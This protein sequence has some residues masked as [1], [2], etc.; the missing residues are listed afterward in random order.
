MNYRPSSGGQSSK[1]DDTD[2]S[3]WGVRRRSVDAVLVDFLA[4]GGWHILKAGATGGIRGKPVRGITSPDLILA[5]V[6]STGLSAKAIRAVLAVGK[7]SVKA[8]LR[9]PELAEKIA[10][11]LSRPCPL[12]VSAFARWIGCN[13]S[14]LYALRIRGEKEIERKSPRGTDGLPGCFTQTAGRALKC[15]RG[16]RSYS[17]QPQMWEGRACGHDRTCNEPLQRLPEPNSNVIP[18]RGETRMFLTDDQLALDA[19][20]LAT[21]TERLDEERREIASIA[22]RL[23]ARFPADRVLAEAIEQFIQTTLNGPAISRAA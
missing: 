1:S 16:H 17:P 3:S 22:A 13:P 21:L 12:N 19:E 5:A 2:D 20:R 4:S 15:S 9:R 8:K 14:T 23:Q 18:L 7:P 6:T 11:L 10:V